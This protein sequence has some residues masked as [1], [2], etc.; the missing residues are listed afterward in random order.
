MKRKS[1]VVVF[2]LLSLAI[3]S[4]ACAKTPAPVYAEGAEK[5]QVIA[6]VAPFAQDI[7]DG[8]QKNDYA[9]FVK[10]FDAATAKAMTQDNFNTI[11][12]SLSK[13]GAY[14]SHEADTVQIVDK[15][16]SVTYKVVY[17]KGSFTMRIVIPKEGT[18]AVTGL[19]F[20]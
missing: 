8:I 6:T 12:T 16:Y 18:A 14:Q 9:T 7:L 15:F 5:D 2:V 17:E 19:W 4:T 13:L 3:F 20:K 10:D 1:L 11:V